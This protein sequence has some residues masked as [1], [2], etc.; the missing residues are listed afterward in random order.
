MNKKDK[1]YYQILGLDPAASAADIK[2]TYRK[3]VKA[4]HP[5]VGLSVKSK[6]EI[7]ADTE[8]MLLINEAYETLMDKSKRAR[9]DVIIGVTIEIKQ[10]F[11]F[12]KTN[13]DEAREIFLSRIFYPSRTSI[14]KLLSAFK[15]QIKKLEADPFDDELV[16]EFEQY[17]NNV[18]STLRRASNLFQTNPAP[19]TLEPAVHMMRHCIAQA[20]DGLDEMRRFCHNY[21]YDHLAMADNLFRIASDLARQAFALTKVI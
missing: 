16:A 8:E 10:S 13:E 9:Y 4:H 20:S 2:R 7:E 17:L 19:A 21:D 12:P 3:I 6:K 15:K 18:E 1:T 14:I 5:D 11:H